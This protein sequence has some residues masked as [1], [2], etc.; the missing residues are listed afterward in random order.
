M[1]VVRDLLDKQVV[2][3]NGLKM[4]R[5][6]SVVLDVASGRPPRVVAIEIGPVPLA[7]R[8][9]PR[10]GRLVRALERRAGIA[11]GRPVRIDIDTVRES[12]RR[13]V[14]DVAIGET[15]A[16]RVE[17]WLRTLMKRVGWS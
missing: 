4:G 10:A 7:D 14:A 17:L 9:G 5:A 13:L 2:D 12:A 3:R 16:G 11:A 15:G 6:D 1:D 8:I